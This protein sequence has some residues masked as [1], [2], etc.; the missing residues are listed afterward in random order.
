MV[1]D[2]ASD[3]DDSDG[4]EEES[5]AHYPPQTPVRPVQPTHVSRP[6]TASS[7][8]HSMASAGMRQP[9][10]KAAARQ[11]SPLAPHPR[12]AHPEPE[13]VQPYG[14]Q[15][16]VRQPAASPQVSWQQAA[17]PTQAQAAATAPPA[18]AVPRMYRQHKAAG[19]H[20]SISGSPASPA[21][22]PKQHQEEVHRAAAAAAAAPTRPSRQLRKGEAATII[23]SRW[24]MRRLARQ[25]PA[26]QA[27][28]QASAQLR[29]VAS[30]FAACKADV[31]S[32]SSSSSSGVDGGFITHK[33]YLEL[34]ELAMRVLL[35][36]DC[37]P[38]GVPELR[39]VRKRLA[40]TAMGLL[41]KIQAAFS[42]AVNASMEVPDS[43]VEEAVGRTNSKPG[44]PA[45]TPNQQQQ[46]EPQLDP[47]QQQQQQQEEDVW[48]EVEEPTAQDEEQQQGE[49][50]PVQQQGPADVDEPAAMPES[51]PVDQP[52]AD[53]AAELAA[54]AA[55]SLQPGSS[56]RVDVPVRVV[57]RVA[58][59]SCDAGTQT[60]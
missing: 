54:A 43:L 30:K 32:S 49:D 55:D 44:H 10:F 21:P 36:L 28:M 4:D 23:Q 51:E 38:C 16:Q 14:W 1:Y 6:S 18:P 41:D 5:Y 8:S 52:A 12:L 47:Q 31:S 17:P 7:S 42:A 9:P 46:Q 48:M 37:T 35:Q 60:D 34:N 13:V 57:L 50:Q 19:R 59:Q 33:Q 25:Q 56:D 11:P 58:G 22:A 15:Q 2:Y 53:G 29:E 40:A 27:L 26:L 24:R 3:T 39:A 45:A 20:I